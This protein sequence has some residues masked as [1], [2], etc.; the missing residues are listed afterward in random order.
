MFI[1]GIDYSEIEVAGMLIKYLRLIY[2]HGGMSK[3]NISV[4]LFDTTTESFPL[5]LVDKSDL[6]LKIL[7]KAEVLKIQKMSTQLSL[8]TE[9]Q[10][11]PPMH[12]YALMFAE[13]LQNGYELHKG[14]RSRIEHRIMAAICKLMR[15]GDY[16]EQFSN[17][18]IVYSGEA[19]EEEGQ[20]RA[21]LRSQIYG[22][23]DE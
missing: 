13:S 16:I 19:L 12:L 22:V 21:Q 2:Q 1:R 3:G 9:L 6:I 14:Q 8:F 11:M 4:S 15:A 17:L 5:S 20:R 7:E 10:F 23:S 18:G